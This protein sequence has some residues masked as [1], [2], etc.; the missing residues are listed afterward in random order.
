MVDRWIH[1]DSS[2]Y[3]LHVRFFNYLYDDNPLNK[4]TDH[5]TLIVFAGDLEEG[6]PG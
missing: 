3:I 6:V 1:I 5:E 4:T 2:C